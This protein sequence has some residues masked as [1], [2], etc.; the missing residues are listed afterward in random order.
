MWSSSHCHENVSPTADEAFLTSSLRG[1]LPIAR[2]LDRELPAPGPMTRR[3]WAEILPW[4]ES[5]GT[6]P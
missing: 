4:L 5:G 3:L 6:I 2:L 1:M